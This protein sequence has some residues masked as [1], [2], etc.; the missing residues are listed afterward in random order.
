MPTVLNALP[1][2]E[3]PSKATGPGVTEK[4]KAFQIVIW[5]SVTQTN[6]YILP[7]NANRFPAILDTGLNDT[8]AIRPKLL[9]QWT[10]LDWREFDEDEFRLRGDIRIPTRRAFL[11][12][13]PNLP[14]ER[15]ACDPSQPPFPVDLHDGI[16]VY[17]DGEQVGDDERTK[18]LEGP[19]LPLFGLRGPSRSWGVKYGLIVI[20]GWFSFLYP[21]SL[22]LHP[23]LSLISS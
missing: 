23:T 5:V 1:Y 8:F 12:L 13:H 19:R 21:I 3:H 18:K 7:K 11:W 15:D 20:S 17:G 4:I 16:T 6:Q 2:F 22:D 9:R 10:G 14:N